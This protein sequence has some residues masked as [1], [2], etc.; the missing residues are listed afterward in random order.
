M[1]SR[2]LLIIYFIVI[3]QLVRVGCSLSDHLDQPVLAISRRHL[4][5][6]S[7]SEESKKL[8][9]E[10]KE[11]HAKNN[12]H[13]FVTQNRYTIIHIITNDSLTIR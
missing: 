8:L 10:F 9:L 5:A 13:F 11:L 2:T 7:K 6:K 12:L 3:F 4:L 1:V